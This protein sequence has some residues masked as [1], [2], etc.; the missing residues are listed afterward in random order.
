M[1]QIDQLHTEIDNEFAQN[2][3]K[4][5]QQKNNFCAQNSSLQKQNSSGIQIDEGS[6][7]Y[8]FQEQKKLNQNNNQDKSKYELIEYMKKLQL[9]YQKLQYQYQ[10][11]FAKLEKLHNNQTTE[12]NNQSQIIF[13]QQNQIVYQIKLI[14]QQLFIS[15]QYLNQLNQNK[16]LNFLGPKKVDKKYTLVLDLDE[17]LIHLTSLSKLE[18]DILIRPYIEEFLKNMSQ[19]F[20]I[21]V[22]TAALQSYAQPIIDSIDPEKY[23]S[24]SLYRQHLKFQNGKYIK[25]LSYL[26]RD[27]SKTIIVDNLKDNFS[28]QEENGYEIKDYYGD[29]N[30]CELE[31]L[32]KILMEIVEQQVEDVR[33]YLNCVKANQKKQQNNQIFQKIDFKQE[34]LQNNIFLKQKTSQQDE[35][36]IL[37]VLNDQNTLNNQNC[38]IQLNTEV[39]KIQ[40]VQNKNIDINQKEKINENN[41]QIE[42]KSQAQLIKQQSVDSNDSEIQNSNFNYNSS[43]NKNQKDR[44][45]NMLNVSTDDSV[46]TSQA[47]FND[48]NQK[49]KQIYQKY[50]RY[51]SIS[52]EDIKIENTN[53]QC[54]NINNK[55]KINQSQNNLEGECPCQQLYL[56]QSRLSYQ[57]KKQF[58]TPT[59]TQNNIDEKKDFHIQKNQSAPNSKFEKFCKKNQTKIKK[60]QEGKLYNTNN[61]SQEFEKNT[62]VE[63]QK[64]LKQNQ[65]KN[66]QQQEKNTD[67]QVQQKQMDKYSRNNIFNQKCQDEFQ[68]QA[69]NNQE[70]KELLDIKNISNILLK[71][72]KLDCNQ[73]NN[74]YQDNQNQPQMYL[75]KNQNIANT[76]N[77]QSS[78]QN[79][80]QILQYEKQLN[81]SNHNI[82]VHELNKNIIDKQQQN[83]LSE[84]R[85][86]QTISKEKQNQNIDQICTIQ[87]KLHYDQQNKLSNS[88]KNNVSQLLNYKDKEQFLTK[89]SNQQ[90]QEKKQNIKD[91]LIQPIQQNFKSLEQNELQF[92]HENSDSQN[93]SQNL[94]QIPKEMNGYKKYYDNEK[95]INL[96]NTQN[97][98]IQKDIFLKAISDLNIKENN[99]DENISD[100]LQIKQQIFI[101]QQHQKLSEKK[102]DCLLQQNQDGYYF[103]LNDNDEDEIDKNIVI[104]Q[105]NENDNEE[106]EV[107]SQ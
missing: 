79:I 104:F 97:K 21:V 30:D 27:L 81:T 44:D 5:I 92:F 33:E 47:G 101:Q 82:P 22:F 2:D 96:K 103:N 39:E 45:L 37:E 4:N 55:T 98:E 24:A 66:T 76:N 65:T 12:F 106:I 99:E 56:I 51:L 62:P 18:A 73:Q 67:S 7:Q 6:N 84:Q 100:L 77:N 54:R 46:N 91:Q 68:I 64:Q 53:E 85:G 20:E 49:E 9:Q 23:I 31:L 105:E 75:N 69:K 43:T 60:I 11:N 74:I 26:G 17:T 1:S 52:T 95:N 88:Q 50:D 14:Q 16:N 89:Q 48:S 102:Q 3:L 70:N 57:R 36:Q 90:Y 13:N 19:Y 38:Q 71:N 10:S 93:Q 32:E 107:R 86:K 42:K 72:Q 35:Q 34:Q 61:L 25:D 41:I 40:E 58:L 28:A 87:Q 59:K 29:V 80:K 8:Q 15:D 94:N 83:T 63:I 78:T